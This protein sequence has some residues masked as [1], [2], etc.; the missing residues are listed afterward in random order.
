M[1][2]EEVQDAG[3][4]EHEP[5]SVGRALGGGEQ[6][7]LTRAPAKQRDQHIGDV[8]GMLTPALFSQHAICLEIYLADACETVALTSA[9][10]T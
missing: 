1:P 8:R 2:Q 10:V 7:R 9:V 6:P 3:G 5:I 4:T